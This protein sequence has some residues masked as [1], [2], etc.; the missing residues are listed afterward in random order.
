MKH[1]AH[2]R[3][4]TIT[5]ALYRRPEGITAREA[6]ELVNVS[7]NQA[8]NILSNLSGNLPIWVDDSHRWR[9][10]RDSDFTE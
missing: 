1:N 2:Q 3:A 8:R 5:I 7:N 9:L 10:L 4:A 6:A